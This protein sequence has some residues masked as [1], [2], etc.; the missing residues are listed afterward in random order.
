MELGVS[1]SNAIH[2]NYVTSIVHSDRDTTTF[3]YRRNIYVTGR[4]R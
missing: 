4:N 1:E 2:W 3:L